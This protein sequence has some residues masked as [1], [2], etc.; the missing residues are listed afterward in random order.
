[1]S[2][3]AEDQKKEDQPVPYEEGKENSHQENDSKDERSIAN[4]LAAADDQND[5]NEGS[6]KKKTE[7]QIAAEHDP[8]LP[9]RMHGNE[10]SRGAKIDKKIED[11]EAEI[12]KR[13]DESK[14]AKKKN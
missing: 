11:E 12:I 5:P 9:A 14:A 1:M 6:G 4:R 3:N 7:E 8:T 13:M 10:P 2:G